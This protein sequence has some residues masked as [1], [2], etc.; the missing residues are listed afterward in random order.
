MYE[1]C[2]GPEKVPSCFEIT[3]DFCSR[4]VVLGA[5]GIEDKVSD[6]AHEN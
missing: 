4:A 6:R 1:Q 2:A 3:N 5:E